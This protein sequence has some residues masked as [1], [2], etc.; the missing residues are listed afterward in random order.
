MRRDLP[1]TG[2]EWLARFARIFAQLHVEVDL[3][4]TE[5]IA[6]LRIQGGEAVTIADDQGATILFG[7]RAPSASAVLEEV[8]HVLQHRRGR[9]VD[10]D[11]LVMRCLREIEAKECLLTQ[12]A[13]FGVLPDEQEAT[14]RQLLE[15]RAILESLRWR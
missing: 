13:R 6:M 1:R 9:F 8:A 4:S 15:E 2:P 5:A 14:H 11:I 12:G 7:S 3:G 10:Q